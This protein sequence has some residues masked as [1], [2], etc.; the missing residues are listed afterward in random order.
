MNHTLHQALYTKVIDA[1]RECKDEQL[2][3]VAA[4]ANV[5]LEQRV[6]RAYRD[7]ESSARDLTKRQ[8]VA[9]KLQGLANAWAVKP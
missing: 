1:L 4:L 9:A 6:E 3:Q 5:E 7:I 8:E 2:A